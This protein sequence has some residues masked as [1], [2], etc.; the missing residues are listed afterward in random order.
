MRLFSI[1]SLS[2]CLLVAGCSSTVNLSRSE[3]A[4]IGRNPDITDIDA[5]TIVPEANIALSISYS[6]GVNRPAN[7]VLYDT[8]AT[9]K[10]FQTISTY[11]RTEFLD[12][13]NSFDI[14]ALLGITNTLAAG[15]AT[16]IAFRNE[17]GDF[18][19]DNVE[20]GVF[21]RALAGTKFFTFGI[22]P[23]LLF[24]SFIEKIA[25]VDD[26]GNIATGRQVYEYLSEK[27]MLF[28]N[29]N[30]R[31][32][33]LFAG[34]QEKRICYS[35]IE[36]ELM[37]E[38]TFGAFC[39]CNFKFKNFESNPYFTFPLLRSFTKTDPPMQIGIK[40]TVLFPALKLP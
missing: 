11:K 20:V 22:R 19:P 21:V 15:F 9:T 18:N 24:C 13:R 27:M 36:N 5:G 6:N 3:N 40:T 16:D 38:Y 37:F 26:Q 25:I 12:A 23:E 32:F 17:N 14:E 30:L 4:R 8:F 33:S 34:L 31:R 2:G 1:L 7:N 28:S 39:G 35:R 29:I 10:D